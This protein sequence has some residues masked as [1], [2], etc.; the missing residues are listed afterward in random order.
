[1]GR[2]ESWCEEFA[3]R[4]I[5]TDLIHNYLELL[6]TFR[7]SMNLIGPMSADEALESLVLDSLVAER[8]LPETGS[9]VDVGSGAGIPGVLLAIAR[10]EMT[11][12]LVE[13]RKKRVQF[14]RV[15]A[16]RLGLDL[17][18]RPHRVEEVDDR[19]DVAISKAFRPPVE[20]L[21]CARELVFPG[22]LVIAMHAQD[23]LEEMRSA[24][25]EWKLSAYGAVEDTELGLRFDPPRCV[26]AWTTA[27]VAV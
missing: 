18:I 6:F 26:S 10:P 12:T 4:A 17:D 7:S 22:G 20:W 1:M 21:P 27:E 25:E 13:P 23:A 3:T 5:D 11:W 16:H 24:S 2:L 8:F 15:V 9:G 19:F 14:L